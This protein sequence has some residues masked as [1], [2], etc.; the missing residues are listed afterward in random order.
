[1]LTDL[2]ITGFRCFRELRVPRLSRVNLF[3]GRN[4]SG[5]TSILEA[6][7]ILALGAPGALWRSPRRRGELILIDREEAQPETELDPSHLF[8]GHALRAGTSFSVRGDGPPAWFECQAVP[9]EAFL[10]LDLKSHL[11]SWHVALSPDDGLI[12]PGRSPEPSAPVNFLGTS[13][14]LLSRLWSRVVLTPEED[15][16]TSA[17]RAIDPEIE[18]LAIVDESSLRGRRFFVKLAGSEQRLPLGSA[19]DGLKRLLA[20]VLHLAST[21]GGLLLVDEIDTGLHHTVMTDMWKLVIETAKRLDVQVLATTH[22]LDCV[23]SLAWVQ[24]QNPELSPEVTLHRV[25]KDMPQTVVYSMDE[26]AI[27]ARHH[28]EVR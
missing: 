25:E 27:A 17:L 4:N 15:L 6:A 21:Q 7:E 16:V 20:L 18:R 26:L 10:E 24:D 5:K 22:S 12:G 13:E 2:T 1:V 8:Y 28:I 23:R 14:L 11:G 9:K 3:V 19:G